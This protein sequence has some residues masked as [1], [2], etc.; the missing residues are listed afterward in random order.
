MINMQLDRTSGWAAY[1]WSESRR[2]FPE[3]NFGDPYPFRFERKHTISLN[4]A[5]YFS[6]NFSV[7]ASWIY[8]SGNAI[9][10]AESKFLHPSSSPF[11]LPLEG[12]TF[13]TKNGF[14]L[15]A[16]HRLDVS[17]RL[18]FPGPHV[19]HGINLSIYNAYNKSNPFYI[20]LIE[21]E[22][23][24]S[25]KNKQFTILSVIPSLSYSLTW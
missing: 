9:T 12:I 15:P 17:T 14:R 1:S 3:I 6:Q 19:E 4:M 21:D 20:T 2:K 18:V 10:L 22:F 13:G 24:Q 8:G 7:S 5:H 25:F 23:D 16:Y 11:F